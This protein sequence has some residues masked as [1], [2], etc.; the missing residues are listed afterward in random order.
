MSKLKALREKQKAESEAIIIW[1]ADQTEENWKAVL[2]AMHEETQA[3]VALLTIDEDEDE[4][5]K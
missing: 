5:T 3:R 2:V 1:S 4:E